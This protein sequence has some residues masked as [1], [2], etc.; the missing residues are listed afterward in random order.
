MLVF[1]A[2]LA[3]MLALYLLFQRVMHSTQSMQMLAFPAVLAQ[4]LVLY[5]LSLRADKQ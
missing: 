2:V 5:P 1:H 3:L 4:M